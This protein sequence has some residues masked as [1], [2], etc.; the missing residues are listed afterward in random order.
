VAQ[1]VGPVVNYPKLREIAL[2]LEGTDVG[3]EALQALTEIAQAR[4]EAQ[5]RR[6]AALRKARQLPAHTEGSS[7]DRYWLTEKAY[8]A[9]A[10]PLPPGAKLLHR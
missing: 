5:M 6:S 10:G 3:E 7:T 2:H 9:L 1:Q 4:R 8:E